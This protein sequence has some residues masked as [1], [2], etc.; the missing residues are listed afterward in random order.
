[1]RKKQRGGILPILMLMNAMKGGGI[2][3]RRKTKSGKQRGSGSKQKG[4]FLLGP[5]RWYK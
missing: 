5:E 1:M 4:G 3:K 2:K